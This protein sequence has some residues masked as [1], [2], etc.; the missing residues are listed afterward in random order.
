MDSIFRKF[1][2]GLYQKTNGFIPSQPI[3]EAFYPGDFFQIKKG[4][5]IILGNIFR[6]GLVDEESCKIEYEKK[7]NPADWIIS[8]GVTTD[9][10]DSH[11]GNNKILAFE[12]QGSCYF[13][14]AHPEA[15][16]IQNWKAIEQALIIKLTQTYYSFREVYVITESV[17]MNDWTLAVAGAKN[18]EMV[19][20]L[21]SKKLKLADIFSNEPLK[22]IQTRDIEYYHRNSKRIPNF[23]KAKK[24]DIQSTSQ[25][26][27]ISEFMNKRQGHHEWA[28]DFYEVHLD[29]NYDD[30]ADSNIEKVNILDILTANQL[31][32]NTA[33]TYFTWVDTNLDDIEKLFVQAGE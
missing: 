12:D 2:R 4:E 8:E 18:A 33:L 31:N 5:I 29:S 28:K 15:I 17:M 27:F 7:L 22:P 20:S 25:A 26:S 23:F 6:D 19:F 11:Q 30:F 13:Q 32:P 9:L 24:L 3:N 21:E 14:G 10:S 1:Y 16:K